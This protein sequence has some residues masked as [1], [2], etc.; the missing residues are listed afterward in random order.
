[1]AFAL[2]WRAL[3]TLPKGADS[4]H[5]SLS[6]LVRLSWPTAG[7]NLLNV[8]VAQ[9][10][11]LLLAMYVGRAPGVTVETFGVFCACA[12]VAVGLRKVRQVFDPIFAP[13]VARRAASHRAPRRLPPQ[14]ST[15]K[16]RGP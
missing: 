1:M 12:E 11:V 5:V 7:S 16:R 2:A 14:R 6:S 10:D 4:D 15:G 9:A 8:L 3:A 13:V